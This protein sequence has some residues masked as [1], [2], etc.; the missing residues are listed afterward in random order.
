[1]RNLY[2]PHSTLECWWRSTG[3]IDDV[4]IFA[5]A[6]K[7]NSIPYETAVE[8]HSAVVTVLIYRSERSRPAILLQLREWPKDWQAV[9]KLV[10]EMWKSFH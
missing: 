1:M 9:E 3:Q 6:K 5:Y 2:A 10:D 4:F 8:Q 7:L